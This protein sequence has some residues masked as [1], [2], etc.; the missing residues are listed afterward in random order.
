M[1][2]RYLPAYQNAIAG[3]Q[4]QS[5]TPAAPRCAATNTDNQKWLIAVVDLDAVMDVHHAAQP[6]SRLRRHAGARCA[7]LYV[8][9][10][11]TAGGVDSRVRR[12]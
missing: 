10:R 2:Y 4:T 1:P 5:D 8:R 6:H 7:K 3:G 11:V 12:R 9:G